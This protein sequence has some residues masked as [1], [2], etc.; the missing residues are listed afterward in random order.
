MDNRHIERASR[1]SRTGAAR[2]MGLSVLRPPRQNGPMGTYENLHVVVPCRAC[3]SESERTPQIKYGAC[4]LRDLQTGDTV[5]W[6]PD[7][8]PA[9]V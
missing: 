7:E 3:G 1:N 9:A 6:G 5:R 4:W 2:W 8:V